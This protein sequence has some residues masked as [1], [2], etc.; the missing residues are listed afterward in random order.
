MPEEIGTGAETMD[1]GGTGDI[2]SNEEEAMYY[3]FCVTGV[4]EVRRCLRK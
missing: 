2:S 3:Y 1:D 4:S